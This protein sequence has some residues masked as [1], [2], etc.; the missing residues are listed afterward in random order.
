MPF[1]GIVSHAMA[2]ELNTL[3]SGGRIGKI[4]QPSKETIL[5][6][7]RAGGENYR[8]L[9]CCTGADARIQ[10]TNSEAYENPAAPPMFCMLLRKHISGGIIR[11]V[12]CPDF[13]RIVVLEIETEDELGDRSLKKLIIEVMGRYSNIIVL[14]KDGIILDALRHI[15]HSVNRVREIMP[16]RHYEFP[17]AQNKLSLS[18]SGAL[19]QILDNV[20][21][22]QKKL[23]TA[24][25]EH[26]RGFSP[27]LCREVCHLSNIDA[28]K[29]ACSL[30]VKETVQL[31]TA[32][33]G[34]IEQISSRSFTPCI[35]V[36]PQSLRTLDF[37]AIT[38]AHTGAD[39][40]VESLN[41]ALDK[42]FSE[43][44]INA[45]LQAKRTEL[46]R[47][48][49]Q[50]LSKVQKRLNEQLEVLASAEDSS[51]WLRYGELLTSNIHMM[52]E[53]M[54]SVTLLDWYQEGQV[55]VEIPL[56]IAL[57]PQR[58]A[59]RYYRKYQ[60]AKAAA[61]YAASQI[62]GLTNEGLYLESLIYSIENAEQTD[63]FSDIREEMAAQGYLKP[64][65][66]KFIKNAKNSKTKKPVS[67]KIV[68][69]AEPLLVHS[70]FGYD[71]LIGRNNRQNDRL[72][73]KIAHSEDIWFHVKGFSGSHVVVRAGGKPV[74]DEVL[75]EAAS[76]A[77]WHSKA[78]NSAKVDIDYTK[79]RNVRKPAG[80]K[81]GMVIY[82]QYQTIIAAP[83]DPLH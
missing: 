13:E 37:H 44:D 19:E 15:D 39:F 38:L 40:P 65:L 43:R 7:V 8:L 61:K 4:Q 5:F 36:D 55:Y 48:V 53:E 72:T 66:Q 69:P 42:F 74:P 24:L 14:H 81:P 18:D 34:I 16:A 47:V 63:D 27:A 83:R 25:L 73:L 22:S 31:S 78:R 76:Y 30:D 62:D 60:K 49:N 6:H 21:F 64:P 45:R 75:E 9:A 54:E 26:I 82:V 1:D 59:Q 12:G 28:D 58:N 56:D 35:V 70:K 50:N 23:A 77:A 29:A 46:L 57:S 71:I 68:A 67:Q 17:P 20:G 33:S 3:L 2:I 80:G 79:I 32:L 41:Y 51:R 52:Q 10:L 11:S